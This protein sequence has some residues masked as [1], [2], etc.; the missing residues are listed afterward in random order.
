M[1]SKTK[2]TQKWKGYEY[3]SGDIFFDDIQQLGIAMSQHEFTAPKA[4]IYLFSFTANSADPEPAYTDYLNK[5]TNRVVIRKN[6]Y[7]ITEINDQSTEYNKHISW[8]WMDELNTGDKIT[9]EVTEGYL[10]AMPCTPVIF[11]AEYTGYS[12]HKAKPDK[13]ESVWG[14]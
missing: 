4:G 14:P 12:K 8:V 6:G 3:F 5:K 13:S 2:T 9:F 1:A 7:K 10:H 11:T